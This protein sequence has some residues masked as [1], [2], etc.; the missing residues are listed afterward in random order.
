MD[1]KKTVRLE[2]LEERRTRVQKMMRQM[3]NK[4]WVKEFAISKE[5]LKSHYEYLA[6]IK[7][8]LTVE[9]LELIVLVRS[10]DPLCFDTLGKVTKLVRRRLEY[11][12]NE[13][14]FSNVME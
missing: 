10:C 1:I 9:D 11:L 12:Q 14:L 5:D 13:V 7:D 3:S 8:T 6:K 2:T 4:Q